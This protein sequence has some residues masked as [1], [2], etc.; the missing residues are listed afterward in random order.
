LVLNSVSIGGTK[1]IQITTSK[2]GYATST[3]WAYLKNDMSVGYDDNIWPINN[4]ENRAF[5]WFD[6]PSNVQ[7]GQI[8]SASL[9]FQV[10]DT[11]KWNDLLTSVDLYSLESLTWTDFSTAAQDNDFKTLGNN[12]RFESG[13]QKNDSKSF[14]IYT[15]HLQGKDQIGFSFI[16]NPEISNGT[17]Q[18][19]LNNPVL[20]IKYTT[21]PT[22]TSNPTPINGS[23][24]QPLSI[25][26]SWTDNDNTITYYKLYFGTTPILGD[27]NYYGIVTT[28]NTGPLALS[29]GTIY[30][31][32]IDAVNSVGTTIG[33]TWHFTTLQGSLPAPEKP[34]NPNPLNGATSVLISTNLSWSNGGGATNYNIYLTSNTSISSGDLV[35]SGSTT[36]FIPNPLI[37]NTTYL[38]RIDAVNNSGTTTGD[39]WHFTTSSPP[40]SLYPPKFMSPPNGDTV[41]LN[42]TLSWDYP[43][44]ATSFELQVSTDLSN[45]HLSGTDSLTYP[46]YTFNNLGPNLYYWRVRAKNDQSTSAW[47]P[48]WHFTTISAPFKAKNP[49][50]NNGSLN[51]SISPNLSWS[52]GSYATSYNIYLGNTQ[53]NITFEGSVI[54]PAYNPGTLNYNTTYYWRIDA[55]NTIDTTSGDLWQFTTKNKP[56]GIKYVNDNIPT[57]YFLYQNFPNPFNPST[58]IQ[59]SIPN[60]NYVT[61]I[62]FNSLGK[63]VKNLVQQ[64]LPTGYYVINFDAS[65][66]PSGIYY[67]R[68]IAGNYIQVKKAILLK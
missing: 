41:S 13:V 38:W 52:N 11:S 4:I 33:N 65:N 27:N 40:Q 28:T 60:E 17:N 26:L 3:G 63:E 1:T 8:I 46:S 44:G 58:T 24:N 20:N 55:V 34:I 14:Y 9:T 50:P 21:L 5:A 48:I 12:V 59:F 36:N 51:Q 53:N 30:Y 18:I 43:W 23:T 2:T 39:I 56:T 35:S 45:G 42:P 68:L 6:I 7:N 67:Y 29:P 25:Y 37:P 54:L 15:S 47:S 64:E 62:I 19:I 61:L 49:Q 16:A 22:A 31:W 66:L 10:K 32:R 57:K